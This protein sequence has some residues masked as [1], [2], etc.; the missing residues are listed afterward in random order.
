MTSKAPNPAKPVQTPDASS[1]ERAIESKDTLIYQTPEIAHLDNEAETIPLPSTGEL[2]NALLSQQISSAFAERYQFLEV[3]GKGG[4][5]VVYKV[6]DQLLQRT[7]AMKCLHLNLSYSTENKSRFFEEAQVI[8]QLQ[9]PNIIPIYDFGTMDDGAMYYTMTEVQGDELSTLIKQVHHA[10]R[11]QIWEQTEN[12]W[13]FHRLLSVFLQVCEAIAFAHKRTVIHR[14]LK[15]S[16]IMIGSFGEVFVMDWGIAK[17]LNKETQNTQQTQ[18]I[19]TEHLQTLDGHITGTPAYM[20]PEQ[21]RGEND[22]LDQRTDIYALGAILHEILMGI[23]PYIGHNTDVLNKVLATHKTFLDHHT[24]GDH[25]HFPPHFTAPPPLAVELVDACTKALQ[26]DPQQRFQTVADFASTVRQWVEGSQKR[27]QALE[28]VQQALAHDQRVKQLKQKT[29]E[30]KKAANDQLQKTLP[31]MPEETKAPSWNLL[32][33]ADLAMEE[34]ELLLT[35]REQLL[36]AALT[37]SSNLIEAHLAL[38]DQYRQ[39]HHSATERL[40]K[41]KMELKLTRHTEALPEEHPQRKSHFAYLRGLGK[42]SVQTDPPGADVWLQEYTSHN[43][44]LV[45]KTIRNLGKTPLQNI[46]LAM[47]SYRLIIK[48]PG[49]EDVL[50]PIYIERQ[51]H[52]KSWYD[53]ADSGIW[54]PPKNSLDTKDKYVPAGWHWNGGD[55]ALP[56][57]LPRRR[58]WIDGMIFRCF[59]VR[60]IEYMDFLNDLIDAGNSDLALKYAPRE[61]SSSPESGG[62]TFHVQRNGYFGFG[63]GQSNKTFANEPVSLVDWHSATAYSKWFSTKQNHSWR[64]PHE[65]EWEKAARGVDGRLY[66]WGDFVDPSWACMRDSHKGNRRPA[67]VNAYPIDESP[68]GI[69][70]MGGNI[71]DWTNTI[72]QKEGPFIEQGKPK[73]LSNHQG[74]IDIEM[75]YKGGSWYFGDRFLR[76]ADR[77]SMSAN[78]RGNLIGFRLARTVLP[79]KEQ[80]S[81]KRCD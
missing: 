61:R 14:D 29:R 64:L 5:G 13:G 75:V 80:G 56:T 51:E 36:H 20:A 71:I 26:R 10:S 3:L 28:I 37:Y 41:Q 48:K 68:Y 73:H 33:Q 57:S 15:P 22:Q 77:H 42:L 39:Q 54:L 31:W 35:Q 70:G 59:P 78:H 67:P 79:A 32:E 72:Y 60:N 19:V 25:E 52:W 6:K 44:R 62:M 74:N 69:R 40:E 81:K 12:G 8:A 50:Y 45:A 65:F 27:Q 49:F 53:Q 43:N 2:Q 38:A 55:P 16:N 76:C 9:H 17:V 11:N 58:I 47:G 66:P 18:S 23:P 7:L 4:M 24:S 34:A 1:E 30:L 46:S 63:P 21:A